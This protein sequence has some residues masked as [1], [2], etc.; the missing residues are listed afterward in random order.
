VNGANC[1]LEGPK[2]Y[3]RFEPKATTEV[4]AKLC[5]TLTMNVSRRRFLGADHPATSH[6]LETKR[7]SFQLF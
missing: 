2:C 1:T 7:I 3:G 5:S 6:R 4:G